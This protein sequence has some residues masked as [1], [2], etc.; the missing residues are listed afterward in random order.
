MRTRVYID[1]FSLYYGFFKGEKGV[2]REHLKWLNLRLLA[3][4]LVPDS[5]V[6]TVMY[7][8]ARVGDTPTNRSR[9]S[10]QDTYIRALRL[11]AQVE[12]IE[13]RFQ[14]AKREGILVK[15]GDGEQAIRMVLIRQEKGADVALASRLLHDSFRGRFDQAIVITNDSDYCEPF[16][17][18]REELGRRILLYS[19]DITVS[20]RL[21]A[22]SDFARPLDIRLLESC[23][24]PD[25]ILLENGHVL[26]RPPA[27]TLPTGDEG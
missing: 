10:R 24:L 20:K 9:A 11:H 18:A 6:D 26:T 13:G 7:F 8:T 22:V 5:S 3:E 1:G 17:I 15:P 27:W 25:S 19:P 12:V 4:A 23:Q 14:T 21:A 2:G 16:R